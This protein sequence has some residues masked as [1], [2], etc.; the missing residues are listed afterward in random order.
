MFLSAPGVS[1]TL[2]VKGELFLEIIGVQTSLFI[3]NIAVLVA[4]Y[5]A[6]CVFVIAVVAYRNRQHK[7]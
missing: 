1:L 4:I 7:S 2:P 5:V 6:A 3:V